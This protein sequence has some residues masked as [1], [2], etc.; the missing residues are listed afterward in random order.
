M[1]SFKHFLNSNRHPAKQDIV[2]R[3]VCEAQHKAVENQL[4]NIVKVADERH[5]D[6]KT[7]L[8]EIK[9]LIRNNH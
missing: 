7:D 8:G 2:F 1:F 4:A 3:D 5:A 6:I 9:D